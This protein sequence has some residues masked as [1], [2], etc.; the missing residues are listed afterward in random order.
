[1]KTQEQDDSK[2]YPRETEQ[3]RIPSLQNDSFRKYLIEVSG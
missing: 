1:M 3:D 2:A